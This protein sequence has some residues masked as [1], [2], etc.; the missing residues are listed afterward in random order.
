MGRNKKEEDYVAKKLGKKRNSIHEDIDDHKLE[1]RAMTRQMKSKTSTEL[2]EKIKQLKSQLDKPFPFSPK[3]TKAVRLMF[4][5]DKEVIERTLNSD[6]TLE[7]FNYDSIERRYRDI[8]PGIAAYYFDTES[9][10]KKIEMHEELVHDVDLSK[11]LKSS[12]QN[13]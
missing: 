1:D 4:T 12:S 9:A 7:D 2:T 11:Y 6:F 3:Q 8:N 5:N 10:M 13:K